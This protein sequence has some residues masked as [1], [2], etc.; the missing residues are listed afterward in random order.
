LQTAYNSYAHSSGFGLLLAVSIVAKEHGGG[1]VGFDFAED[2]LTLRSIRW[3]TPP[4]D[5]FTAVEPTW[6]VSE[7]AALSDVGGAR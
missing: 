1:T 3:K 2:D 4:D 5:R 6:S 7:D